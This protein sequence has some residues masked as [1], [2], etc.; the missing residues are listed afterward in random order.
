MEF[1]LWGFRGWCFVLCA[2]GVQGVRFW[3]L[4][5]GGLGFRA[6]CSGGLGFDINA[7]GLGCLGF[8]VL[9]FVLWGFRCR[10]LGFVR[11]CA[12]GA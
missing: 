3:A 4:C 9:G 5:F 10:A 11:L 6:L 2:F 12:L 7:L 1:V 8:K